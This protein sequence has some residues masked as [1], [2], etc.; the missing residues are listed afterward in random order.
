[1]DFKGAEAVKVMNNT[2]FRKKAK[3]N[4]RVFG[5][6]EVVFNVLYLFLALACGFHILANASVQAQRLAGAMAFLLA[7]GDMFHLVPRI[8]LVIT[9]DQERLRKALG[10]GKLITSVTMTVFY[11]LLWH[12][13]I[14]LFS[15]S[16]RDWSAAIYILG[17]LRIA[18][19]LL[20]YNRWYDEAP[21]VNWAV[22]RNLPFL[23]LGAAAAVLYGSH[24][25]SLPA[26]KWMWLA[27]TLSFAFYVPVVLWANKNRKLGMLMLPKT[28]MYLW[29]LFMFASI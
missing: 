23:L 25:H 22:Y 11:M 15:P 20:K 4:P 3:G 28:C 26:L 7:A 16:G 10:L 29:I 24:M 18:L 19:C 27:V 17:L 6:V 13:G 2:T 9:G 21:P 14:L 1:M 8:A 12:I 5:Y